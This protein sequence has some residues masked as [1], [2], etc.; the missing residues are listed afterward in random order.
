MKPK[1]LKKQWFEPF[2]AYLCMTI[3][4]ALGVAIAISCVFFS[5]CLIEG[6]I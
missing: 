6:V 1:H 5:I 4:A 3:W 2:V